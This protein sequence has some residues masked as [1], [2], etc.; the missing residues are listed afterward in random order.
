ML[1]CFATVTRLTLVLCTER[2]SPDSIF[3]FL[4]IG[5]VIEGVYGTLVL[6]KAMP[7]ALLRVLEVS[8]IVLLGKY[9]TIT[10]FL[11]VD[12][13]LSA[14]LSVR[15]LLSLTYAV[16]VGYLLVLWVLAVIL[17]SN[18]I[19]MRPTYENLRVPSFSDT[20]SQMV[21]QPFAV[22]E[23]QETAYPKLGR[24]FFRLTLFLLAC[25][26]LTSKYAAPSRQIAYVYALWGIGFA[27][28]GLLLISLSYLYESRKLWQQ[29]GA[30]LSAGLE[31]TWVRSTALVLVGLMAVGFILPANISPLDS[32]MLVGLFQW[33]FGWLQDLEI[34][35]AVVS[36]DSSAGSSTTRS[37]Q[38]TPS[39]G[40]HQQLD[41]LNVIGWG[42]FFLGA[43]LWSILPQLLA[44]LGVVLILLGLVLWAIYKDAKHAP[45][46]L[47]LPILF[48]QWLGKYALLL[49]RFIKSLFTVSYSRVRRLGKKAER[50][51]WEEVIKFQTPETTAE[52]G[53]VNNQPWIRRFFSWL[54]EQGEALGWGRRPSETANEYVG[55]LAEKY[56][57]LEVDLMT[58]GQVYTQVRYSGRELGGEVEEK[59]QKSSERVQRRLEQ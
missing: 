21:V 39:F 47:R 58:I 50:R 40:Y 13:T 51:I 55:K 14:L 38:R 18:L 17:T 12:V 16:P 56:D 29:A 22:R 3:L 44:R 35:P 8:V 32:S 57:D 42:L 43:F 23:R 49:W 36:P 24:W 4:A 11:E 25:W 7:P 6:A 28:C 33:L 45:K 37:N 15:N 19:W 27:V 54:M 52:E 46:A 1:I 34:S 48:V 41:T 26:V 20:Y 31:L 5:V 9:F 53:V 59:A 30:S 10:T 2:F